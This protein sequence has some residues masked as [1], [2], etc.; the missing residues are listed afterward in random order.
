MQGLAK[1]ILRKM[2]S[3]G[4]VVRDNVDEKISVFLYGSVPR[5]KRLL[6]RYISTYMGGT[7]PA[8][9]Y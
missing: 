3:F 6:L 8:Q 4:D 5:A 7:R 2:A 1:K 9:K